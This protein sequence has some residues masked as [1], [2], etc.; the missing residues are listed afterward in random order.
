MENG[1]QRILGACTNSW[2][3]ILDFGLRFSYSLIECPKL[4]DTFLGL[5]HLRSR[6]T[7]MEK[8]YVGGARKIKICMGVSEK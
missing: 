3:P 1:Y 2:L 6:G 8:E 5:F 7:G 4:P